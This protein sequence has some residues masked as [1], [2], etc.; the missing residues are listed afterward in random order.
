MILFHHIFTTSFIIFYLL[1]IPSTI[2]FYPWF[3]HPL[4]CTKVIY[5]IGDTVIVHLWDMKSFI[6]I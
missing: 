2:L 4:H 5:G 3:Q 6:G 1:L